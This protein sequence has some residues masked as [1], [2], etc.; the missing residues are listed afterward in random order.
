MCILF[1][2]HKD[3]C[4]LINCI[5]HLHLECTYVDYSNKAHH[6]KNIFEALLLSPNRTTCFSQIILLFGNT[7][8]IVP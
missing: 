7:M 6:D 4:L 8:K 1:F 2:L 5:I 3:F